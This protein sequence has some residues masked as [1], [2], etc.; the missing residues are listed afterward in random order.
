[1]ILFYNYTSMFST[2]K[3]Y[4]VFKTFIFQHLFGWVSCIKNKSRSRNK[5]GSYIK[6]PNSNFVY[7]SEFS[8]VSPEKFPPKLPKKYTSTWLI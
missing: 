5:K 1:M 3:Y 4:D 7:D 2:V 8:F 6:Y